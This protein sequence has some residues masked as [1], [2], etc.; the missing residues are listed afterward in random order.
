[1][2]MTYSLKMDVIV[3]FLGIFLV[4]LRQQIF[5]TIVSCKTNTCR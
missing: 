5:S 4:A 2:A 1:M 3:I